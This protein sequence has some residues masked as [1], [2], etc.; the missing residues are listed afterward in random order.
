LGAVSQSRAQALR[1]DHGERVRVLGL[2]SEDR[3]EQAYTEANVLVM[4][5]L[6][7]G[8]GMPSIE[9]MRYG[10]PVIAT[11]VGGLPEVVPPEMGLLVLP[12]S[13]AALAAGLMEMTDP[14]RVGQPGRMG[15]SGP[16]ATSGRGW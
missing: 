11:A 16:D 12:G 9:A 6:Y 4:P 14:A 15:A 10:V 1:R 13:S 3:L 7:E 8:F 2:V 5:S